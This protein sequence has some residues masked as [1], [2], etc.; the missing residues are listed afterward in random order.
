MIP[1]H[2]SAA[3]L[4]NGLSRL[5][6]GTARPTECIVVDDGSTD[7]SA[8]VARRHGATVLATEE[9]RGPAHARNLGARAAR[10]EILLFLDADVRPAPETVERVGAT[11]RDDPRLEALIGS[12]DDEPSS[13]GFASQYKNLLHCFVHQSAKRTASTFWSGCGAIR[14]EVFLDIG[15][16]D[17]SYN[18]PAIEDIELGYRLVAEGKRIALDPKL[19]VKHL[20]TWT[21]SSLIRCDIFD[22]AIPWT[23]LI[24][25]DRLMPDDLNLKLS[26]RVCVALVSL[27]LLASL[28]IPAFAITSESRATTG[29]LLLASF[30]T[31]LI[32]TLSVVALNHRFFAF[33]ARKRGMRFAAGAVP[34]QM[35]YHLYSGVAFVVGSTRY[36]VGWTG[37]RPNR[38][39][40]EATDVSTAESA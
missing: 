5:M 30:G 36:A 19:T 38:L 26:Q 20:K 39:P 34:M 35:G 16:F 4:D 9:R 32:A 8:Q 13:P 25:R 12:Y 29:I 37:E 21:L 1:V 7:D 31:V 23:E 11:F 15:G 6:A 24:W 33:L 14:R 22:R 2:Q 40:L 17:E 10:G 18:R 28:A 3:L 27:L